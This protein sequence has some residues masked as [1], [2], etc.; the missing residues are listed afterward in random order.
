[1]LEE[2]AERPK[3]FIANRYELCFKGS[4][5]KILK[6]FDMEVVYKTTQSMPDK[7]VNLF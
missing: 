1:M 7:L 3:K 2:P 4:F 5:N 6:K